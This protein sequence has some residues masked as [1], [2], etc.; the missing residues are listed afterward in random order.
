M[1]IRVLIIDEHPF[2]R[3]M[4]ARRLASSPNIEMVGSTGD[5][6]EGLRQIKEL[7]PDVVLLETK[8]RN[9]DGMD[10]CRRACA[11]NGKAKVAVLTSYT[12]LE[13]RK[14]AYALGAS[15]YL[16][17]EVGTELLV[18]QLRRMVGLNE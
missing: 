14:M 6:E 12:D 8:M 9:A 11:A 18:A 3:E 15:G 13:E 1:S 16:L 5:S 7:A 4:L 2:A 17:K 10:V